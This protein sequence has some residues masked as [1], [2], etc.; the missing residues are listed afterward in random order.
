[1]KHRCVVTS[2]PAPLFLLLPLPFPPPPPLSALLLIDDRSNGRPGRGVVPNRLRP[3]VRANEILL[4]CQKK[5]AARA[6]PPSPDRLATLQ[7]TAAMKFT[8]VPHL[9]MCL[10][11]GAAAPQK[12]I[13]DT[14]MVSLDF[15]SVKI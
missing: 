9:L 5:R 13:V 14:D 7:C 3:L 11:L 1:M 6:E 4:V 8:T 15:A 10:A 12:L 2:A